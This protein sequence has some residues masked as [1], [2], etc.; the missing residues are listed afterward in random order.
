MGPARVRQHGKGRQ[1]TKLLFL[2][3]YRS[4]EGVASG[5]AIGESA[6]PLRWRSRITFVSCSPF[7]LA[8]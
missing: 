6:P 5:A 8:L 3:L 7:V 2:A 1:P 4:P